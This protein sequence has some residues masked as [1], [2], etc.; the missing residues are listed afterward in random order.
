MKALRAKIS[1]SVSKL[2]TAFAFAPKRPSIPLLMI[3]SNT[4]VICSPSA[5]STIFGWDSLNFSHASSWFTRLASVFFVGACVRKWGIGRIRV[6]VQCF[7]FL[8]N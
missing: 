7:V 4:L 5:S 3:V 6:V 2:V 1:S 8:E